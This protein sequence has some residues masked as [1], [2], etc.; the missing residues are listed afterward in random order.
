MTDFKQNNLDNPDRTDLPHDQVANDNNGIRDNDALAQNAGEHHED[1]MLGGANTTQ[2]RINGEVYRSDTDDGADVFKSTNDNDEILEYRAFNGYPAE[3]AEYEDPAK[4]NRAYRE[5]TAAEVAP[6]MGRVHRD[7]Q[8]QR[9]ERMEEKEEGSTGLGWTALV[10]SII[11]LFVFP[12]LLGT[13]GII[14]G[15]MAFRRNSRALGAWA[16]IIGA[17][18]ILISLFLAPLFA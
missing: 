11:S 12:V 9:V 7:D 8:V 14:T 6:N 15:F 17:F 5:E 13:V 2:L 4:Q 1:T 18:S 16:M 3:D 10:L